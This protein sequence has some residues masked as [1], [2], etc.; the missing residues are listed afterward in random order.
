MNKVKIALDPNAIE[1]TRAHDTDAGI[2]LYTPYQFT[3]FSNESKVIDTG[4]HIEVPEGYVAIVKAKS[5][6]SVK[7]DIEI[8]AGVIDCGYSGSVA[9]HLYNFGSV[10]KKFDKGNKIAQLL[11]VPIETPSLEV[12]S[13]DAFQDTERGSDG[14]GSTGD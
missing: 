1:P 10:R 6:L 8:G 12:V 9:V 3:I 13:L 5:G 7:S 11:I 4:V 2:D 14:F